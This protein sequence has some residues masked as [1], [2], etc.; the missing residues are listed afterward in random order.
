MD[1]QTLNSLRRDLAA[2]AHCAPAPP[3]TLA[4]RLRSWLS[5]RTPLPAGAAQ[6]RR[7]AAH[8]AWP[9]AAARLPDPDEPADALFLPLEAVLETFGPRRDAFGQRSDAPGSQPAPL[10]PRRLEAAP[11]APPPVDVPDLPAP[12]PER[13]A[14]GAA[15]TPFFE[16]DLDDD[17]PRGGQ[18]GAASPASALGVDVAA[19]HAEGASPP[20]RQIDVLTHLAAALAADNES[21]LERL[22]SSRRGG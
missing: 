9:Q 16:G 14:A 4:S 12:R 8:G 11:S 15:E 18:E 22:Q 5:A 6:R 7:P 1:A 20:L 19:P 2:G 21:L 13:F 10:G 17:A 3:E